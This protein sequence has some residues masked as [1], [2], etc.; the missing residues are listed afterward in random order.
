MT[1]MKK[2]GIAAGVLSFALFCSLLPGPLT[3][4]GEGA[5]PAAELTVT[6]PSKDSKDPQSGQHKHHHGHFF[7]AHT[8]KTTA[9]LIGM[10]NQELIS[11]L[12][13]GRTLLQIVQEKKGWSE[14]EYIAKLTESSTKRIDAAVQ[15]GKLDAERAGKIKAALPAKLK[16]TVNRDWSKILNSK[17][18]AKTDA[19]NGIFRQH[20]AKLPEQSQE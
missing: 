16:E 1:V 11:Q 6:E 20:E 7:G 5:K 10:D 2:S 9:E 13:T 12:K 19:P 3:A 14:S 17:P 18:D 4:Y 15:N 8:I